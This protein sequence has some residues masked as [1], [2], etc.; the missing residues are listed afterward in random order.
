MFVK[1]KSFFPVI[2]VLSSVLNLR[3]SG[4]P[5]GVNGGFT[6]LGCTAI[7]SLSQ[8]LAEYTN[9]TF[10]KSYKKLCS[11]LPPPFGIACFVLGDFYLPSVL[12]HE[13]SSPDVICHAIKLCYTEK[14]Q[15]K[16]KAYPRWPTSKFNKYLPRFPP[17]KNYIDE[18]VILKD[19]YDHLGKPTFDICTLPGVKDV[20]KLLD[21]VFGQE[22][23]FFD[24]D[25]DR[26]SSYPLFRGSFW[27]GKDCNDFL[28][29]HYP[30]RQP[31]FNDILFDSNC[32]GISGF[33]LLEWKT[34]EEV[35]C[36]D[37]GM[38]GTIVLGDSAAAHFRIPSEWLTAT[39]I[40]Q[41]V[42]N[43]LLFVLE[44]EVDWPMLSVYTGFLNKTEWPQIISGPV[45][46]IYKHIAE[47][48]LCNHR[49]Y[50]NIGKNGA[51][52]FEMNDILVKALARNNGIDHPAL[53]FYS[54]FGND[55]C[56]SSPSPENMTTPDEMRTNALKTM[57]ILD[58]V[59]PSGSHVV[60]LGLADGRILYNSMH[61]RIH[62]IGQLRKDVT[63][64]DFYEF[65]NCLQITPCAGWLN[66]NET[67]RNATAKRA[68]ELSNVLE[69][70]AETHKYKNFDLVFLPHFIEDTIKA[71]KEIGKDHEAWQL[72]EPVDGFHPNQNAQAL[73][74]KV[75]VQ[76]LES[77][78]PHFLGKVNPNN[79]LIKQLF[80]NQGG[81]I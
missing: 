52:S 55:V 36:K 15:P 68:N 65:L 64:S 58:K 23:P 30:G 19:I 7:V 1:S 67:V 56:S 12:P 69:N 8:Q 45:D 33:S 75:L 37:T 74:A 24:L 14:G 6:C 50:Q 17:N 35:L 80:G 57:D 26:F 9:S 79:H 73:G 48:N 62:P 71:W 61:N 31:I 28:N 77:K 66:S 18:K 27:R 72:I 11:Y 29:T 38:Q 44:N 32:N 49:D 39:A 21:C 51:D 70:I 4:I 2:L 47:R 81:Y 54:L 46:S 63:Y 60:M 76:M 10:E 43:D 53:V 41:K 16:C 40:N 5:K 20:C 59:L 22:L 13:Q 3:V 78:V 34:W 42:F 25:G